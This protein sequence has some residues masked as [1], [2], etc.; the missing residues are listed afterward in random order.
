MTNEG[1]VARI[2][3]KEDTGVLTIQ[4]EHEQIDFIFFCYQ[5]VIYQQITCPIAQSSFPEAGVRQIIYF[6]RIFMS[7][8]GPEKHSHSILITLIIL[9]NDSKAGGSAA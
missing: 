6:L 3:K 5:V 2:K 9:L 4:S 8:K 1:F 7:G